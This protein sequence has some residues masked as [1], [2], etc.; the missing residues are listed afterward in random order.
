MVSRLT[1]VSSFATI[2]IIVACGSS[3]EGDLYKNK[4]GS[5][6][7]DASTGGTSGISGASTGGSAGSSGSAGQDASTTGG[8]AGA[9]ED[10][11]R[12]AA[13]DAS[14]GTGG[15][16]GVG[17]GKC[18]DM[19]CAFV[20][21]DFCCK[22]SNGEAYCANDTVGNE[23]SCEGFCNTVDIHCD[24]PEDCENGEICCADTGFTGGEY[25]VVECRQT[26]EQPFPVGGPQWEV[27]HLGGAPC[28]K[29]SCAGDPGLPAGYGTCKP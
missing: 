7:T 25:N 14:G 1:A 8:S 23:C 20:A 21:D 4:P 17:T 22:P 26:C 11:G 6:G 18:G 24:G 2:S 28:T 5:G 15:M 27:C 10:A 12:D 9:G 16:S 29:G 3:S 19:T 13:P